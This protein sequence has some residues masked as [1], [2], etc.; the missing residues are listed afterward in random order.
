MNKLLLCQIA[1][2]ILISSLQG[3]WIII[4]PTLPTTLKNEKNEQ[5]T[6]KFHFYNLGHFLIEEISGISKKNWVFKGSGSAGYD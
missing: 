2:I 4:H 1:V 3:E 6:L 5:F